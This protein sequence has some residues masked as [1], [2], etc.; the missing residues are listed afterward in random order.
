M[1]VDSRLAYA[2]V[3]LV[4]FFLIITLFIGEDAILNTKMEKMT[5]TGAIIIESQPPAETDNETGGNK[6]TQYEVEG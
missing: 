3:I 2:F 5:G 4:F 6:T 1:K